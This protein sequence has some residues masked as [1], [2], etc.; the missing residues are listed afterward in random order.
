MEFFK[1][2]LYQQRTWIGILIVFL[3][4]PYDAECSHGGSNLNG[5]HLRIASLDVRP[6]MSIEK[7]QSTYRADGIVYQIIVWLS[8]RYNFTF[9]LVLPPDGTFGALV[10]HTWNGMIGMAINNQ[11]EIIAAPVVPS[12]DRAEVLDFTTTFSE[13]PMICLIPA[14]EP[15]NSLSAIAKP[16]DYQVWLVII[17]SM[18]SVAVATWLTSRFG[19]IR[20]VMKKNIA[21]KNSKLDNGYMKMSLSDH[22]FAVFS[23]ICLQPKES[24]TRS[25][26]SSPLVGSVWCL[27]TVVLVY[28]YTG[29]LIS[30]LTIPKMQPIVETTEELA[31]SPRLHVVA[32]KNSIFESTLLQSTS[33]PLQSLG[34]QLRQHPE[35]SLSGDYYNLNKLLETALLGKFGIILSKSQAES[36]INMSWKKENR[37]RLSIMREK[38][39]STRFCFALPKKSPYSKLI[40]E[41]YAC[42]SANQH[43]RNV[44]CGAD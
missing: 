25:P 37:C 4:V 24:S 27:S 3:F 38:I 2:R 13:E 6:Y 28:L 11:V 26:N 15:D 10:N 8:I 29:V 7:N 43:L 32:I 33:G 41:G 12:L 19:P 23:I 21:D 39:Q 9:S 14:P 35:N 36:L 5:L 30:Y 34:N 31:A 40:S 1:I 18:L 44:R 42:L 17:F 20:Q 22:I 16:Y